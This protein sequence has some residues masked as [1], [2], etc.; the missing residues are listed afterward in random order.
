MANDEKLSLRDLCY[1]RLNKSGEAYLQYIHD[2]SDWWYHTI[3]ITHYDVKK[4]DIQALPQTLSLAHVLL[5]RGGCPPEDIGGV[6][7]YCRIMAQLTGKI[8]LSNDSDTTNN[9][10]NRNIFQPSSKEWWSLRNTEVRAK[11]NWMVLPSPLDID[12]EAAR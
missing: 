9:R 5:G 4:E 10:T 2:F 1:G 7:K 8:S 6:S 12:L 11:L 3:T